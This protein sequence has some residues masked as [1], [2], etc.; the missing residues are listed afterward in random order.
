MFISKEKKKYNKTLLIKEVLSLE[1][2]LPDRVRDYIINE[3]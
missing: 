3:M 1:E 2:E